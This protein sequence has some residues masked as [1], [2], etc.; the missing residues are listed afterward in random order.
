MKLYDA[1]TPNTLRVRVFL[2][3]KGIDIPREPVAVL[4]G[5]TR[6]PEFL[7]INPLGE[8][9]ALQFDDG[10]VLTESLAICRYLEAKHPQPPLFGEGALEQAQVVMWSRRLEFHFMG[11]IGEFARHRLEFFKD[12]VTQLPAHAEAELRR[13]HGSLGWLDDALSDGR[14]Y[15][16]GGRFTVADITGMAGLFICDVMEQRLPSEFTHVKAWERRL[17][18]RESFA[19]ARELAA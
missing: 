1:C 3:E 18:E 14:P 10:S 15:L 19:Q 2:A 13:F 9:P 5:A 11:A 16:T 6:T 12:K 8:L 17:R 7:K 4:E